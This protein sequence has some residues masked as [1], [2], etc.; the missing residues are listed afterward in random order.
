MNVVAVFDPT[1]VISDTFSVPQSGANE[2]MVVYNESSVSLT[3]IFQNGYTAYVPAWTALLFCGPFGS[4]NVTWEQQAVMISGSAPLS[5]VVVEVYSSGEPVPGTFPAAL[6]RQSNIGNSINVAT[7][8]TSVVNDN[9]IATTPVI[10]TIVLGDG[11]SCVKLSNSGVFS[12]GNATHPGSVSFDNA[13]II[14]DGAG[15]VSLK[16]LTASDF[17][18]ASLIAS[19]VAN[20]F[21]Q[22]GVGGTFPMEIDP[23]GTLKFT[24]G[25]FI[26]WK[27]GDT[28]S[29]THSFAGSATGT[30]THGAGGTPFIVLPVDTSGGAQ[31]MG[32]D[33]ITATQVHITSSSGHAFKALCILG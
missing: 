8:A 31:T 6:V 18:I 10:E 16:K 32:A 30:Y 33:T 21:I 9:N 7:S 19:P 26:T 2:K 25:G 4:T 22:F 3:F 1:I 15:A 13:T 24:N 12:I 28:I 14:S 17:I 27:T 20:D 5:Q 29:G 23:P 11:S